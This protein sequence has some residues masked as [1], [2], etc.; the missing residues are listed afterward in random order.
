[1]EVTRLIRY[2]LRSN[3][4]LHVRYVALPPGFP[5]VRVWCGWSLVPGQFVHYHDANGPM[6]K[7]FLFQKIASLCFSGWGGFFCRLTKN[8]NS[9]KNMNVCREAFK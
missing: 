9:F 8:L 4:R 1:M 5:Y 7:L 6:N 3:G 2:P